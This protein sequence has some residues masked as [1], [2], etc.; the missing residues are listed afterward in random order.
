MSA[1]GAK[2]RVTPHYARVPSQS[3]FIL[4]FVSLFGNQ[5]PIS[6]CANVSATVLIQT[7]CNRF[8]HAVHVRFSV[9]NITIR[10]YIY[11]LSQCTSVQALP[12]K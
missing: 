12:Y 10:I 3:E 4:Q 6:T 11:G 7:I 2:E 9:Y 1:E 5:T 8:L